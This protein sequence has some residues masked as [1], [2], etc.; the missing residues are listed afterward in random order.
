MTAVR[1]K[2]DALIGTSSGLRSV[3][4]AAPIPE[5]DD[6]PITAVHQDGAGLWVLADRRDLY[7]VD[8]DR[9]ERVA[10]LDEGSGVCV[11]T[12]RGAVYVGGARAMLW[13]LGGDRLEPVESFQTAPTSDEWHTPWGGPPDVFSIASDGTRFYVSVHVGGIL[14]SIDGESWTSTIDLHDDVHQVT[15]A[16]DGTLWAATGMRGLAQSTDHG[17]TWHY[18][19]EGLHATYALAVAAVG[20]GA[21]VAVSSGHAG[22]DGAVYRFGSGGTHRCNGLP[23]DMHGA[24]GPKQLAAA[25]DDAVVALPNGDIYASSNGGHDWARIANAVGQVSEVTFRT[26]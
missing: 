22:R 19:T 6:L 8:G 16:P 23:A 1:T 9:A 24:V 25:G 21:L 3:R 10:S 13:R 4:D 7:R 18:H 11:G 12:H 2:T 5:L 17:S 15:V 14:R 20:D 26:V